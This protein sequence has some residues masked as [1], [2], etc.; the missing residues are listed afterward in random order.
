MLYL[1]SL[2]EAEKVLKALSAPMRVEILKRLYETPN[3]SMNDLAVAL[4]LTNSAISMHIAKLQEAGLVQL[5][6]TPGKRG[7]M[8]LV[9]PCHDR[10]VLNMSAPDTEEAFYQDNIKIGCYTACKITPTCGISTPQ[11]FVGTV[12]DIK[13]FTFPEHFD[14]SILWFSS[15]YIEYGLPNHLLPSQ[16][17]KKLEISFE[18]ASECP[19]FSDVYPSDIHFYINKK[20]LGLWVSPGDYGERRGYVSPEWWPA[21][22]NQYGLLKRLVI[23]K[24]GTFIDGKEKISEVTIDDLGINYNSLISFRIE[25]PQTAEHCGGCTLYGEEFGDYNQAIRVRAYY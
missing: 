18:I 5:Q 8:K 9:S 16:R 17:L 21:T 13:A 25:V 14:A 6:A 3:Q 23:T 15:G 22:M 11:K 7:T 24:D 12:D 20:F 4:Q 1:S 10:I 19:G 2:D